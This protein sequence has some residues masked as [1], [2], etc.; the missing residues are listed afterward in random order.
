MVPLSALKH[1]VLQ[2]V[3]G[4]G[5]ARP[6][7]TATYMVGYHAGSDRGSLLREQE[8]AEVVGIESIAFDSVGGFPKRNVRRNLRSK[9]HGFHLNSWIVS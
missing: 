5:V 3:G 9:I 7:V 1:Q 6:L 2:H 8:N 4:P